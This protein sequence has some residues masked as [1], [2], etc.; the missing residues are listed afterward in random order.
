MKQIAVLEYLIMFDPAE[1]WTSGSQFE[2]N[3]ADFFN[4]FG[5]EANIVESRGGTGRRVIFLSPI[6]VIK[7]PEPGKEEKQMPQ[8]N[9]QP[10]PKDFKQFRRVYGVPIHA[11][12]HKNTQVQNKP[13]IERVNIP[14]K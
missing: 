13:F 12:I 6:D 1:A 3:F 5:F 4:A 14:K 8:V 2:A 9:K 11:K 7:T 10:P